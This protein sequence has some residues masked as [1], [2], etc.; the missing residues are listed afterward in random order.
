M[1][2]GKLVSNPQGLMKEA[3]RIS[4]GQ[5]EGKGVGVGNRDTKSQEGLWALSSKR[6]LSFP[7][8]IS[9][10]ELYEAAPKGILMMN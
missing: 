10:R 3:P 8:N 6:R 1:T 5:R 4:K 2:V 7:F 9:I